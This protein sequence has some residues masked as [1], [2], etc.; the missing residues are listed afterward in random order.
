MSED[1]LV[2]IKPKATTKRLQEQGMA[3]I[4]GA[5]SGK[6][7]KWNGEIPPTLSDQARVDVPQTNSV[8]RSK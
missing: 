3:M 8:L 7:Q 4:A 2:V 6:Y 1:G 5:L